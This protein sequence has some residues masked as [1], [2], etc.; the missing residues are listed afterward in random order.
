[1]KVNFRFPALPPL[2][3]TLRLSGDK[4]IAHRAFCLAALSTGLS[5]FINPPMNLDCQATLDVL[6]QLGISIQQSESCVRIRGGLMQSPTRTL[7]CRNSGTTLRLVLGM[8]VG[9]RVGAT[10]SGDVSLCSRPMRRVTDPLSQMGARFTLSRGNYA[11][12]QITPDAEQRALDYVLPVASAQVKTALLLAGLQIAGCTQLRGAIGSR[13]HTERLVPAFGGELRTKE[14]A[15]QICGPQRL[16]SFDYQL[17]GDI[18]SAAFLLGAASM[19]YGSQITFTNCCLNPSRT[20]FLR[21]LERMGASI[22]EQIISSDPEPLGEL[23]LNYRA[24]QSTVVT[25][26]EIPYVIDEIPILA[27]VASQC[28]G[29]TRIEGAG[30]LRHKESDRL[31]ALIINLGRVG[32][33]AC[34]DDAGTLS[35]R[36]QSKLSAVGPLDTFGD[37][38]MAMALWILR[39]QCA[40]PPEVRGLEAYRISYPNFLADY[41]FLSQG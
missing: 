14:G 25:A 1:M 28:E 5:T 10:L 38:R 27:V 4:A 26:D 18:S 37:H 2:R 16:H 17:P 39:E 15:I 13:D 41:R 6:G 30:E 40:V 3:G 23:Q 36:G 34:V 21:V 7:D 11:P 12:V 32:V 31:N 9:A 20:G 24:L 22:Q 33:E 8:L 19:R 35:I 29:T